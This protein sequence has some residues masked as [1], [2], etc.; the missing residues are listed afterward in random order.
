[1]PSRLAAHGGRAAHRT[2]RGGAAHRGRAAHQP[3]LGTGGPARERDRV[4]GGGVVR[5]RSVGRPRRRAEAPHRGPRRPGGPR[6]RPGHPQPGAQPCSWR[7][8]AC[9]RSW[10]PRSRSSARGAPP[11]PPRPLGT[12]AWSRRSAAGRPSAPAGAPQ[13]TITESSGLGLCGSHGPAALAALRGGRLRSG[14]DGRC[15]GRRGSAARVSRAG[16][17]RHRRD[18]GGR[19]GLGVRG[20]GIGARRA[21]E[22][23]GRGL[24]RR[25][26]PGRCSARRRLRPRPRWRSGRSAGCTSTAPPI[27]ARRRRR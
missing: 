22:V 11:G 21:T 26:R 15:G 4:A 5:R 1:M 10:S 2:R 18:G 24:A 27:A 25:G 23:V 19:L 14:L 20:L 7:S 17:R 9:A 8:S 3:L 6:Q 13:A 12:G 16:R